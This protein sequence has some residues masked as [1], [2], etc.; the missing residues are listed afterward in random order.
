LFSVIVRFQIIVFV[1]GFSLFGAGATANAGPHYL[2]GKI[3]NYTSNRLGIAIM[4]E[5][6]AIPDNCSGVGYGWITIKQEDTSMIATFFNH[7]NTAR[8]T[9]VTVYTDT[10]NAGK[11]YI[12]QLDPN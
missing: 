1:L 4:F 2:T 9:S 3:I 8:D 10:L 7:W 6:Q 11:C 5:A 12:N